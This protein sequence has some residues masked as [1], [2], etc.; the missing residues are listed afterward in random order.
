[1]R[2]RGATCLQDDYV[3]LD[4]FMLQDSCKVDQTKSFPM[5]DLNSEFG[6]AEL[7]SNRLEAVKEDLI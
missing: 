4:L 3:E 1:M 2:S 6:V 5:V 7:R